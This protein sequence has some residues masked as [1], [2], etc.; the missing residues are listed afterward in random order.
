MDCCCA[1]A[2]YRA[3]KTRHCVSV[4]FWWCLDCLVK[5]KIISKNMESKRMIKWLQIKYHFYY[6]IFIDFAT[7]LCINLQSVVYQ[8]CFLPPVQLL[9]EILDRGH[10]KQEKATRKYGKRRIESSNQKSLWATRMHLLAFQRKK[11][12]SSYFCLLSLLA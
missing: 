10:M 2:L 5:I 12:A 3:N 8:L 6:R 4:D 7:R 9:T 11:H 1:D